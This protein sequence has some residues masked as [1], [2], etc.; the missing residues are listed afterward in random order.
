MS[1]GTWFQI[2][3]RCLK[4]L[5]FKIKKSSPLKNNHLKLIPHNSQQYICQYIHQNVISNSASFKLWWADRTIYPLLSPTVQTTISLTFWA[6]PSH[7]WWI[8]LVESKSYEDFS[9]IA[10][11]FYFLHFLFVKLISLFGYNHRSWH[12]FLLLNVKSLS[13]NSLMLLFFNSFLLFIPSVTKEHMKENCAQEI[14]W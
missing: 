6:A 12:W 3:Y 5:S 9:Y 1:L 10:I 14:F 13:L 11:A 2:F 4:P 7:H 8:E